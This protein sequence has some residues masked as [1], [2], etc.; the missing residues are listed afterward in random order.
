MQMSLLPPTEIRHNALVN[1]IKNVNWTSVLHNAKPNRAVNGNVSKCMQIYAN[2]CK[3]MQ[4]SIHGNDVKNPPVECCNVIDKISYSVGNS[5]VC[6][7]NR[8][9][10]ING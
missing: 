5:L 9:E 4:I 2:L 3:F 10:Q 8:N 1:D 7:R 6:I